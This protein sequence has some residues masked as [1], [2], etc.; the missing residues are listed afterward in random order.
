M[1]ELATYDSQNRPIEIIYTNDNGNPTINQYGVASM[2]SGYID[3]DEI[4]REE[5]CFD[6]AGNPIEDNLGVA[7]IRRIWDLV[8]RVETETYHNLQGKLVEVLYGFCEVH[9]HLDD[10]DQP[11]SVS[12]YNKEELFVEWP[13]IEIA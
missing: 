11:H 9:Y 12:C 6:P 4:S 1:K 5:R 2:R 8:D 13:R 7:M 10:S 3:G